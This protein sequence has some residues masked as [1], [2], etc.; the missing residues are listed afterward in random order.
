MKLLVKVTELQL[1]RDAYRVGMSSVDDLGQRNYVGY[2]SFT[3]DSV[4]AKSLNF[5]Q[6]YELELKGVG[7]G[8]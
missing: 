8:A 3:A 5:E 7:D 6:I 4:T 1:N 2:A